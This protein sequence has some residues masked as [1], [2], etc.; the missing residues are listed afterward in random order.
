MRGLDEAIISV[1]HADEDP[2]SPSTHKINVELQDW[3]RS[4]PEFVSDGVVQRLGAVFFFCSQM[5][6]FISVLSQIVAEK[7][8]KLRIALEMM[9]L[10]PSVFWMSNFLSYGL[11]VLGNAVVTSILG[12][13]FQFDAFTNCDFFVSLMKLP[14]F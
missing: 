14:T 9:G 11:L 4:P 8:M 2:A 10:K 12:I 5:V 13:A 3:P 7:E 1:L 6:I